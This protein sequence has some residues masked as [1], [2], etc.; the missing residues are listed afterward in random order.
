MKFNSATYTSEL[1]ELIRKLQQISILRNKLFLLLVVAPT[2][3]SVIYFGLIASNIYISESRFIVRSPSKDSISSMGGGFSG[4]I[5]K[6]GLNNSENDSFTAEN[7]IQSRDALGILND[8]L[9]IKEVYS[10]STIDRLHRFA[11]MRFWDNSLERFY[12]YYLSDIISINHDESSGITIL[13]VRAY[14]PHL[15]YVINEQLNDL[16]EVLINRLNLRA[17]QDML[18]FA[19]KEVGLAR[20]KVENINQK[21]SQFRN[22]KQS[23]SSEQQVAIFQ[24]LG[25]EKDF[26][27]RN[28]AAAFASLEQARIEAIKKQLYLERVANPSKPDS[29]LEPKRIRGIITVFVLGLVLWGIASMIIAGVKEHQHDA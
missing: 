29:A 13:T 23:G 22:Q 24:Q 8:K 28:L 16:S 14:T 27:D 7:Y 26:A 18:E 21:I 3:L 5:G 11:G 2:L 6:M 4:V 9:K 25:S 20:N 17:R 10:E 1:T 19:Q 12:E 15:A